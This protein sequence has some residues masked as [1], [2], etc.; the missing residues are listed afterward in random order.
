MLLCMVAPPTVP[1]LAPTSKLPQ[2]LNVP[3]TCHSFSVKIGGKMDS[4]LLMMKFVDDEICP[5]SSD[6]DVRIVVI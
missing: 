5:L 2:H 4:P 6:R 3:C 1:I